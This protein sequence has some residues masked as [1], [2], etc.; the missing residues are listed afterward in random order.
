ME[1]GS[2][3]HLPSEQVSVWIGQGGVLPNRNSDHV[4]FTAQPV[5]GLGQQL[6]I[7][8]GRAEGR[9][10]LRV[11]QT[12]LG[13]HWDR[14]SR[15]VED[16]LAHLGTLVGRVSPC[17]RRRIRYPLVTLLGLVTPRRGPF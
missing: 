5:D 10:R 7:L 2:A 11:T 12:A 13:K 15:L 3:F 6:P 8:L 16:V 14:R 4:F 9:D 17:H 1:H